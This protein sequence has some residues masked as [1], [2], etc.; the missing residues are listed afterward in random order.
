L[1]AFLLSVCHAHAAERGKPQPA[2]I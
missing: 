1:N 2:L